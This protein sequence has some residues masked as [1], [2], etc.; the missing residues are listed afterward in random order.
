M[1]ELEPA[2]VES[3][4]A[5]Q[6]VAR[7]GCV[8]ADSLYVVPVIYAY[9][10]GAAYVFTTEGRKTRAMR[11]NPEVCLEADHYDPATGS[12]RSVIAWGRYEE[13]EGEVAEDAR[14]LIARQF[15]ERTGRRRESPAGEASPSLP[16]A[17]CSASARGERSCGRP[18]P[19]RRDRRP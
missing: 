10:N 12:W 6:I 2:E 11:A 15:E 4:L 16:S 14:R 19:A 13:L 17:S 5:D 1:R 3:F 9:E 8:D 18:R 7:I